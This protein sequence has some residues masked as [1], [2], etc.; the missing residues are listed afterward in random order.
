MKVLVC[1]GNGFI[2]AALVRGL[3]AAGHDVVRGLR[4]PREPGDIAIDFSK[5][6]DAAVWLPRLAGIDA[7]VNAVGIIAERPGVRFIDLHQR[8]PIALFEACAKAGVRRVVQ[9]SALGADGGDT[10]YF[11]TKYAA[12]QFLARQPVE[13]Q[14]LRPSLVHGRDGASAAAFRLLASL[15]VIALPS[16]PRTAWFQ[17][18]HLDDLVAAVQIVIDP[19]TPPHQTIACVG[20]TRHSFREMIAAYRDAMGLG[21][22][23]WMKVPGVVMGLA[24]RVTRFIPGVPLNPETWRMLRQGNAADAGDFTRLL[25]RRPRGLA[26]FIEPAAA[27]LLRARALAGWQ[28]PMLRGAVAAVW[29]ITALVTIFV[30]PEEESLALLARAGLTGTLATLALYGAA[31]FDLALGLATL[32]YP[33]RITWLAQIALMLGYTA[34]IAVA[35]PEFLAHPF[36]PILKNLP[37]LAI[38]VVLLSADTRCGPRESSRRPRP[39]SSPSP[40]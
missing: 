29:I 19:H 26:E 32:L 8:A 25:G 13:W 7:V 23:L 22:A 15:P 37:I 18:V 39:S 33:R 4:R 9:I 11:R 35:L 1:G 5:D 21:P 36:G 38:L 17:P 12:D 28:L 40:A 20:A 16:L 3:R 10:E 6:T 14:I 2:G 34:I 30:F 31:A 24:A 27:E